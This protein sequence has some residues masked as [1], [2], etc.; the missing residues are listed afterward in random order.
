MSEVLM[1]RVRWDI[2]SRNF[3]FWGCKAPS[4]WRS[5]LDVMSEVV[6]RGHLFPASPNEPK[7]KEWYHQ[8]PSNYERWA[9]DELNLGSVYTDV[10]ACGWNITNPK[11]RH[12]RHKDD[13]CLSPGGILLL[14]A[15]RCGFGIGTV[16]FWIRPT[17]RPSWW[18]IDVYLT[19]EE[20]QVRAWKH[21]E[22]F[23]ETLTAMME[24]EVCMLE[25]SREMLGRF[26]RLLN[27]IAREK[28]DNM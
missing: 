25:Y 3:L 8:D 13:I 5:K 11:G 6:E 26:R 17:C 14:V 1:Y 9:Y 19:A 22:V 27:D 12:M 23:R 10:T 16:L 2:F 15:S 7:Y 18:W 24:E 4:F 28:T 21:Q 20:E